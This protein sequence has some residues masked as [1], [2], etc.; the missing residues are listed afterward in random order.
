MRCISHP[1]PIDSA[2]FF[3]HCSVPST[4]IF[5]ALCMKDERSSR[6]KYENHSFKHFTDWNSK[7]ARTDVPKVV[8]DV[9]YWI[10]NCRKFA[11]TE[12]FRCWRRRNEAK[13]ETDAQKGNR[14]WTRSN[15]QTKKVAA[16]ILCSFFLLFRI[17]SFVLLCIAC[18]CDEMCRSEYLIELLQLRDWN[19][20]AQTNK[21]HRKSISQ[22]WRWNEKH[23][24]LVCKLWIY[25]IVSFVSSDSPFYL[26]WSNKIHVFF[27]FS[28]WFV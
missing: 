17:R 18:S 21:F 25:F 5:T 28:T 26:N 14:E 3:F 24:S 12:I 6:T 15:K 8:F 27:W 23:L 2:L 7:M 1:F 10:Y 13:N 11:L 19:M 20:C 4:H 22:H 16:N 9:V